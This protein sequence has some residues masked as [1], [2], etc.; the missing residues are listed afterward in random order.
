MAQVSLRA[1][2]GEAF[3]FG[4]PPERECHV[5]TESTGH[6]TLRELFSAVE[7]VVATAM[8]VRQLTVDVHPTIHQ[9]RLKVLAEQISQSIPGKVKETYYVPYKKLCNKKLSPKGKLYDKYVNYYRHLQK[10]G[11]INQSS[12]ESSETQTVAESE[13]ING[14]LEWLRTHKEPFED[15]KA[16]WEA[17]HSARLYM[18]RNTQSTKTIF[19]YINDFCVL[20]QSFGYTLLL[21]DF[22]QLYLDYDMHMW[23][24]WPSFSQKL[25]TLLEL[26]DESD[27]FIFMSLRN[28]LTP[29][30]IRLE[31]GC[32]WKPNSQEVL[33][34]FIFHIKVNND[35]TPSIERIVLKARQ[36]KC[37]VQPL[38]IAVGA[39]VAECKDFYVVI[40]TNYYHF[41]DCNTAVDVCF[42]AI[43]ALH[44]HYPS[45]SQTIWYF[46]QHGLYQLKTSWDIII[47]QVSKQLKNLESIIV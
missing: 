25:C 13:N 31:H 37:K 1:E 14:Q 10:N 36:M 39:T 46:L 42:K 38:I 6:S 16:K 34:G 44:A 9:Q 26:S 32:R 5:G 29:T 23:N 35:L 28:L 11:L 3:A 47:P 33:D 12:I 24:K 18:L 15:V 41:D 27:L 19:D 20:K 43:H 4:C 45:Q 2:A 8:L 40:D 7:S 30:P 21:S 17:T 22:K